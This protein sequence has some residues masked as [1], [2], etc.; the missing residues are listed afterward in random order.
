MEPISSRRQPLV[1]VFILSLVFT[2]VPFE[3][4]VFGLMFFVG[5]ARKTA[6]RHALHHDFVYSK[7]QLT[8]S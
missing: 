1:M 3:P 8:I 4:H 6:T 2:C 5:R 7:V